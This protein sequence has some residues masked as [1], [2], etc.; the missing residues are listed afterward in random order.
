MIFQ[1]NH[2]DPMRIPYEAADY[3]LEFNCANWTVD[4]ATPASPIVETWCL[5]TIDFS[6]N[7]Y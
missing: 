5:M 1:K 6:V 4:V 2:F 7:L 3:T